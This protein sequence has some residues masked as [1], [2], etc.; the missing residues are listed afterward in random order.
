MLPHL[1]TKA[2]RVREVE[3]AILSQTYGGHCPSPAALVDLQH[4]IEGEVSREDGF[5]QLYSH[6]DEAP[7]KVK[8]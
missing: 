7:A 2:Q 3:N 5:R 1:T 6:I 4:Y 8:K